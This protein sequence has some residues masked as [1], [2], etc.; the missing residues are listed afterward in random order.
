MPA[1]LE[2]ISNN[3]A[4]NQDYDTDSH[5]IKIGK[6]TFFVTSFFNRKFNSTAEDK[7]LYLLEQ[8]ALNV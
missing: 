1:V 4:E 5:E 6:S 2:K 3:S 7:L 8:E